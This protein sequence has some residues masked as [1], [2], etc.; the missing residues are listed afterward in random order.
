MRV[1]GYKHEHHTT[2]PSDIYP[3]GTKIYSGVNALR[4]EA[5]ILSG[6]PKDISGKPDTS[7]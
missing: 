3:Y 7:G 5:V 2:D 4:I 1:W 6:M